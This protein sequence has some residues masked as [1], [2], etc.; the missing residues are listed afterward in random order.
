[1]DGHLPSVKFPKTFVT[2]AGINRQDGFSK[3][4]SAKFY[5]GLFSRRKSA[6]AFLYAL[7]LNTSLPAMS[8]PNWIR[9]KSRQPILDGFR[10]IMFG[11]LDFEIRGLVRFHEFRAATG[12]L[13]HGFRDSQVIRIFALG[14]VIHIPFGGRTLGI[15]KTV[16]G[17]GKPNCAFRNGPRTRSGFFVEMIVGKGAPLDQD[18]RQGQCGY[19]RQHTG[20]T[21]KGR[22]S[23]PVPQPWFTGAFPRTTR[24][25]GP[26]PR[27]IPKAWD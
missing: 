9:E 16:A 23:Y 25:I 2:I 15:R 26:W 5:S 19:L 27:S 13:E 22:N 12:F 7:T 18:S 3:G 21:E 10:E 14:I 11:D 17:Q 8:M 20:R 1:M 4:K 24:G 6:R